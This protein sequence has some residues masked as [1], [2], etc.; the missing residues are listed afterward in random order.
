MSAHH[1]LL[2]RSRCPDCNGRPEDT[3]GNGACDACATSPGRVLTATLADLSP[4]FSHRVRD[5]LLQADKA[6]NVRA[7]FDAW[8][9][10]RWEPVPTDEQLRRLLDCTAP[11]L[12]RATRAQIAAF[13]AS[14]EAG[15]A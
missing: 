4:G 10:G 15:N 13:L 12:D 9:A 2:P 1:P 3:F 6:G 5:L 7:R 14:R 8:A 11:K